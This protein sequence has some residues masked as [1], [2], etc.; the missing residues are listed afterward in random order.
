LS[1][2]YAGPWV[3]SALL[4]DRAGRL[5]DRTAVSSHGTELTYAELALGAQRVAAGLAELGVRAGDRVATMLD[6]TPDYLAAWWGT[7]WAGAVEVPVNTAYK[8]EY[9]EHVLRRSEPGVLVL[10][11]RW[12][13][14]LAEIDVPSLRHVVV[15]GAPA[16]AVPRTTVAHPLAELLEASPRTAPVPRTESD[17]AYVLFT[18]GTTGPSKGVMLGNRAALWNA[19]PWL[20]ILELTED[21]VAYSMFPLFH[22]TARSAVVTSSFWAGARVVL[23]EGFSLSGFWPDVR[24][25]GATFFAYMGAV[26]HLLVTA[27]PRPD[28]AE[29]RLRVAFGAA[30]PPTEVEEF[31]RRFGVTLLETYGST[32]VGPASAPTPRTVRR[33][34]MGRPQPDVRIEIHDRDDEPVPAEVPGEIVVRPEEPDR[35]FAGYWKEPAASVAAFANLWFHTGDGGYLTRDGHL[36][37]TDRLRD[38]IRRRG[39]NVSSFEVERSVQRHPDVLECAAFAVPSALTEDEVMIAVVR[40]PGHSLDPLDLF[41]YCVEALPR[42]AVPRYLRILEALPKTPSQRIQKFVLRKEGVTP[43]AVDRERLGVQVPRD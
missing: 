28:D 6:P 30:A 42:F 3:L 11:A 22:V 21:D 43:D 36:V 27:E 16:V 7:A 34:T 15:T 24:E 17:L 12:L 19:R 23:R 29:N 33:G 25:S 20:D 14:R 8:G 13:P 10:D 41:R 5:G 40:R 35:I 9:L 31:Q 1:A 26:I 38:S 37:F 39:E 2:A 32:E 4:A 18:S